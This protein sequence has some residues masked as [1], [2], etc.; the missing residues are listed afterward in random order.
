MSSFSYPRAC[1]QD[2]KRL[3]VTHVGR[4]IVNE[5][6]NALLRRSVDGPGEGDPL[7]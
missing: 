1:L 5:H 3:E 7:A 2:S 4:Y 6:L